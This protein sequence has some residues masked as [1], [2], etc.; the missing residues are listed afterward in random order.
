MNFLRVYLT[1]GS[2]VAAIRIIWAIIVTQSNKLYNIYSENDRIKWL[3]DRPFV[4]A[5]N[6]LSSIVL[7]PVD[8]GGVVAIVIMTVIEARKDPKNKEPANEEVL[9]I[10][11]IDDEEES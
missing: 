2:V 7:W 5:L 3:L 9:Y 6:C 8:V 10:K 11:N 4:Q 1:I